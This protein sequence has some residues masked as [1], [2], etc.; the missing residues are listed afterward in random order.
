MASLDFL[1]RMDHV[2]SARVEAKKAREAKPQRRILQAA[3]V[4]AGTFAC[5]FLLKAVALAH[6]GHAFDTTVPAEA[7]LGAQI[8]HWLA[9]PDPISSILAN[10]LR[11]GTPHFYPAA[12]TH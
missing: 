6:N 1:L 10:A 11:N 8:Y 7:G 2:L 9:D 3:S 4:V 5:F 12:G